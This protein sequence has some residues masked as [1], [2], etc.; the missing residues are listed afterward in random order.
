ML[1]FEVMIHFSHQ[2]VIVR[3]GT[4]GSPAFAKLQSRIADEPG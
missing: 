3:P 4:Q 2:F 1:M